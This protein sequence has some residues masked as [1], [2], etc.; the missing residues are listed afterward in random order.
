MKHTF[1][2][3]PFYQRRNEDTDKRTKTPST[4]TGEIKPEI[5]AE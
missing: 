2:S 1:L 3:S 4:N 5:Q